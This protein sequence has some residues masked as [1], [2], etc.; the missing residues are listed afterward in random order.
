MY[1]CEFVLSKEYLFERENPIPDD[2]ADSKNYE[3]NGEDS[4]DRIWE[5]NL[6][7]YS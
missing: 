1:C 6:P 2:D 3:F 5:D 7:I 4:T